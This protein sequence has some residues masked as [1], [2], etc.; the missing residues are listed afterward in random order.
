M[1]NN[2]YKILGVE[3]N[4][5]PDEIKQA[6]KAA[7]LKYHPDRNGGDEASIIQFQMVNEAYQVLSDVNKRFLFDQKQ[8][9]QNLEMQKVDYAYSGRFQTSYNYAPHFEN[10]KVNSTQIHN[11]E[12]SSTLFVVTLVLVILTA[13]VLYFVK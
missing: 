5:S 2:Y 1:D 8:F 3:A 12:W 13:L 11:K 4:A 10:E 7:A 9:A 6:F